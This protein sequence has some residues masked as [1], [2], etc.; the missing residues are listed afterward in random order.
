MTVGNDDTLASASTGGAVATGTPIGNGDV[1]AGR[2][3]IVRFLGAGGMGRVYEAIDTELDERVALKVVHGGLSE[4]ALE[5]FRR[6]VKL[7]R[8]IQHRNVARMFDIGEHAHERFLTMELIDGAA[9]SAALGQPMAWPRLRAIASQ[10]CAG[11]AAAH[12]AGVIHRDL[13]PDNVLI[14]R[15]TERVVITDFGIARS[16]DDVG[17]TQIGA[18][19]GTP[20]YMAPEQLAGELIDHRADVFALGVMLF[21]LASGHRPWGGETAIAIAVAQ[22][23]TAPRPLAAHVPPGFAHVIR[24]CLALDRALRPRDVGALI[25]RIAA[26][27]DVAGDAPR[28]TEPVPQTPAHTAPGATSPRA[29]E[30][31]LRARGELRRFWAEHAQNATELLTEAARLSP[32]SPP[33]LG[34]RAFAAVQAWIM[35]GEPARAEVAR[36]AIDRGL[37]VGHGE[38][39]LAS[40]IFQLNRGDFTAGAAA[41]GT[42]LVRTPMSAPVHESAGRLLIELTAPAGPD[43]GRRHL[44]TAIGLDPGRSQIIHGDL[45][46][47]DALQGRWAEA[48][49]HQNA[50]LADPDP[51]V[52]QLGAVFQARIASWRGDRATMVAAAR[53]FE[54]RIEKAG[55]LLAFFLR[56]TTTGVLDLAHWA[57]MIEM[58]TQRDQPHRMQ[59]LGLQ[60]MAEVAVVLDHGDLALRA[61]GHAADMGLVDVTWLDGCPLFT[62]F[63]ADLA[64]LALR[65]EIARRADGVLAAFYKASR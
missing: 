23:T 60:L 63:A 45:A 15:D 61:L 64:W 32:G 58:F 13:K 25:A 27:G 42:A 16:G 43:D 4:E 19:I 57:R 14:E 31:Y 53:V 6:E 8:R 40:A 24:D 47:L 48:E 29:L 65:D 9:L 17:V 44:E 30:L 11:L 28:I 62:R 26:E 3:R 10:L 35:G 36:D 51:T 56:A 50:L 39:F 20:R 33:I 55:H 46:R 1:V 12:A 7:T 59:V 41:L 18:L 21:E 38:A 49:A 2:Y 22:A 5:R 37:A 34:A 52:R 54:S